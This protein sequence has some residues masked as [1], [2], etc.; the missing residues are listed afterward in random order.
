MYVEFAEYYKKFN[1]K[2]YPFDKY[3]SETENAETEKLF[4]QQADYSLIKDSFNRGETVTITGNRGTGKTAVLL[5]L[6]RAVK[7]NSLVC[8]IDH[9]ED[10]K[11]NKSSDEVKEVDFYYLIS[12]YIVRSLL[13]ATVD[14][15][16]IIRKL[17][18]DDKVF[19]SYLVNEFTDDVTKEILTRKIEKI[20]LGAITRLA[21]KIANPLRSILNYGLAAM[22]NTINDTITLHY[23]SLP[24]VNEQRLRNIL[25]TLNFNVEDNFI[26]VNKGYL[27]LEK[28][29]DLVRKLEFENI[30]VFI[31]KMDE[32]GRFD[33]DVEAIS[34][35]I[36]PLLK[37]SKLLE[38]EHMQL[39]ISVWSIPF[40]Y[41]KHSVRTQKYKFYELKWN[42]A[43]LVKVFNK[44]IEVFSTKSPKVFENFF[45]SDSIHQDYQGQILEL[46]N[47]NPRD[48]WHIFDYLLKE[49]YNSNENDEHIELT[50]IQRGLEKFVKEFNYFEYYPK[51]KNARANSMDIYKYANHLLK[52]TTDE[53]T[54]N[55][56]NNE[57]GTGSSTANYITN[58]VKI[59]LVRSTDRKKS[60]GTIYEI[61]DPK[62]KYARKNKFSL[63]K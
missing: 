20:Q 30:V 49:Q 31:D 7:K 26:E 25:P 51:N 11:F 1:F 37:S 6:K 39:V 54:T 29:C 44:R 28:I 48:L 36:K 13:E 3:T 38:N 58:M 52:L 27:F 21:K 8:Y 17:S 46:A 50:S 40:N 18:K 55:Q 32:D 5:D 41:I 12:K 60:N 9:F 23:S 15:S 14:K 34:S 61:I 53:F 63:S 2:N 59:G 33:N 47:Y 4:I 45:N 10:I 22:T 19:F 43:D 24:I 57:A 16:K 56:L 42:G 35:F 62:I